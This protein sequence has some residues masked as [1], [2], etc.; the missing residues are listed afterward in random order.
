LL[1]VDC[2][3][4]F[5]SGFLFFTFVLFERRLAARQY[6]L[7][8]C[9]QPIAEDLFSPFRVTQQASVDAQLEAIVLAA[10]RP[11]RLLEVLELGRNALNSRADAQCFTDLHR[12]HEFVLRTW[13]QTARVYSQMS[14]RSFAGAPEVIF[15]VGEAYGDLASPTV[16]FW[17]RGLR[18]G[19]G[20]IGMMSFLS[21]GARCTTF[22]AHTSRS[23]R[24]G[25]LERGHHRRHV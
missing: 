2:R 17:Y 13:Q 24:V 22:E 11:A 15:S 18:D 8:A 25:K 10:H 19:A 3:R 6:E 1:R 23:P 21:P 9:V 20:P 12:A 4:D 16:P 5:L 14:E 7:Y